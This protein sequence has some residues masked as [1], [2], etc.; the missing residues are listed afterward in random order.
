[1][2]YQSDTSLVFWNLGARRK[3]TRG[4]TVA[5]EWVSCLVPFEGLPPRRP[6]T[7]IAKQDDSLFRVAIAISAEL[8]KKRASGES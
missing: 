2:K 8:E 5:F 3:V 7:L 6:H 4:D 1:M